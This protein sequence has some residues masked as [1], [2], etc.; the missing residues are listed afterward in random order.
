MKTVEFNHDIGDLV[1]IKD[2]HDIKGRVIGLCARVYGLTYY[3]CWWQDGKRYDEWL[4]DWEI[5]GA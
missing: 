5:E 4:H 2:Y 3:V 1:R